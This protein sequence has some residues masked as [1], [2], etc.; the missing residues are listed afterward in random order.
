MGIGDKPVL[1]VMSIAPN[2]GQVHFYIMRS[3]LDRV[4][5]QN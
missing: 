2:A 3:K 5:T 1:R 4:R